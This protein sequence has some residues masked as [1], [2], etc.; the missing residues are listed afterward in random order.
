MI[1]FPLYEKKAF[2][3]RPSAFD[4]REEKCLSRLSQTIDETARQSWTNELASIRQEKEKIARISQ[5]E[6]KDEG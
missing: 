1:D 6:V 2:R 4:T 3:I 5:Q